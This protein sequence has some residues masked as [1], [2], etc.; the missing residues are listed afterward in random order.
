MD[1]FPRNRDVPLP[2]P[3][4]LPV[5]NYPPLPDSHRFP[6]ELIPDN[7]EKLDSNIAFMKGPKRK[8]LA[9]ACDACH[10]SKRR[11][12]GTAPCSNCYFASKKCTYTD[13]SGKPVPAPRP[14]AEGSSDPRQGTYPHP[15]GPLSNAP[16]QFGNTLPQNGESAST[17]DDDGG[18][19]MNPR[20]R[21]RQDLNL[22]TP[23]RSPPRSLAPPVLPASDRPLERDPA[24][25]R[26]L[27]HLFF[28]YRQPQRMIIH[29]ARFLAD[30]SRNAVPPYLLLAVCAVAAPL[31]KQPK[32]KTS[33]SRYAGE[34][35]AQE[36]IALMY[37]DRNLNCEPN[38]AT[39][40]ALCLLQLHDRMGKSLWNGPYYEHA[41]SIVTKL[42]IFESDYTILTPDP[43]PEFI[44]AAIDRECARRVFWL[45]FISDSVASVLYKRNILATESQLSLRLPMD[46]TSFELSPHT[47]LPEFMTRPVSRTVL[48]EIGQLIQILTIHEQIERTMDEFNNRENGR[49]PGVK[50]LG[51][52]KE[53]TA[54]AEALPDH[55]RFTDDNLAVQT[56]IYETP[57]NTGAWCFAAMHTFH[58]SCVLALNW[59]RQRCRT[60][61]PHDIT[62][63]QEKLYMIV[64]RW[65]EKVKLSI[66]LG[67]ILWPLFK[68]T[69]D[70]SSTLLDWSSAFEDVWGVRIQDLCS[71]PGDS[72]QPQAFSISH[73]S[74]LAS[75]VHPSSGAPPGSG[76]VPLAGPNP[77][78]PPRPS[79]PESAPSL[80]MPSQPGYPLQSRTALDP[81][82][83]SQ[84]QPPQT[85]SQP[86]VGHPIGADPR[87]KETGR[88]LNVG[89]DSGA[90]PMLVSQP[91]ASTG[92][93]QQAPQSL[94]SLKA[95]GLLEWSHPGSTETP[96]VGAPST[97]SSTAWPGGVQ[98][99]APP[100]S[101][102]GKEPS[103]SPR[104]QAPVQSPP[105][106]HAQLQ[107][108]MP[109]GLQWL[110]H[111]SMVARQS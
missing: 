43:S 57:S 71:A 63:A 16:L 51:L 94:P 17:H 85:H 82:F 69:D 28:T 96:G 48:S 97:A 61:L 64:T 5:R 26:E 83:H 25:T 30:L 60:T 34:G 89:H 56:N 7:T 92:N 87:E 68:Y 102:A 84:M 23:S 46:E 67:L 47:A 78:A 111:E 107:V 49:Q 15:D 109:V 24:L 95:S 100:R 73:I 31:S 40:Q 45:I 4:H 79:G 55:L 93:G 98:H 75:R 108:H 99:L 1:H 76:M 38:L 36:A 12:D 8:R 53:V 41:M 62:D 2:P 42:G 22:P 52:E 3:H 103:R 39:A 110:A 80:A 37:K 66:L 9:K 35:F 65:G 18:R 32:L 59:A 90:D 11:C 33:P 70:R 20:K 81:R 77:V 27:V 74:P 10:K 44:N 101:G 105:Q 88:N 21:F 106:T 54:W 104:S 14:R 29:Q 13:A 72:R 50:L 6:P 91:R 86:G 19:G 58:N